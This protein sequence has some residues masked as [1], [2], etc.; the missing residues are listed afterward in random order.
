MKKK[1]RIITSI[2]ALFTLMMA[3][4]ASASGV[5]YSENFNSGS[6]GDWSHPNVQFRSGA[7]N[8]R[9]KY[10]QYKVNS[11]GK[12]GSPPMMVGQI[13]ISANAIDATFKY[14]I[15]LE[16]NYDTNMGGKFFG[17]GPEEPVTG[18]RDITTNGWSARVGIR[19][20]HPQLYIYRQ[21]KPDGECGEIIK[22]EQFTFEK[23]KWYDIALYVKVNSSS[24]KSDAE[25]R[26]YIDGT[27]VAKKTGF[28]FF[29][30]T[31]SNVP[32]AAKIQKIIRT[33]FLGSMPSLSGAVKTGEV[34]AL[35][36]NFVV[37]RGNQP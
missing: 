8:I 31:S 2:G 23:N 32:P 24:T 36:D 1:N 15:K 20:K 10:P 13:P 18:C 25:A 6:A 22:A 12:V 30:G 17:L 19:D 33:S 16:D 14:R 3:S 11:N 5:L 21:G 35:Y 9:I 26:L 29:G 27:E 34:S 28:K 37:V 4:A 7:N